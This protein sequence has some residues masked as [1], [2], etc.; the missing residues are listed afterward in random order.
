MRIHCLVVAMILVCA[1]SAS[2]QDPARPTAAVDIVKRVVL[3]PTTYAP[4]VL[5]YEAHHLDWKSSQVFFQHGFLEHSA[6][7][8]L[9]GRADDRPIDYAAGN[10][11]IVTTALTSLGLSLANNIT[12][13]FVERALIERYPKHR[14]LTR[15]L[16]WVE[17]ISF[18]SLLAYGESA[19]HLRQWRK[20]V[21]LAGQLGY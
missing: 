15:T 9:S 3:D 4:A 13:A 2:A 18:A 12:T 16:G 20:N 6:E 11:R 1:T 17:R 5:S 19:T 14:K 8:T 7:F 21:Q 10:R